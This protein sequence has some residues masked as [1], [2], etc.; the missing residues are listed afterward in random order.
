MPRSLNRGG[1]Y[2]WSYGLAKGQRTK[3]KD[4]LDKFDDIRWDGPGFDKSWSTTKRP[5][6]GYRTGNTVRVK[7]FG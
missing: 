6:E 1:K 7:S 4:Y 5:G 3:T 2:G